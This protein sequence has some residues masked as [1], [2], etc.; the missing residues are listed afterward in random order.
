MRVFLFSDIHSDVG[1][2]RRLAAAAQAARASIVI[3]AGD[4]AEDGVHLDSVYAAFRHVGARVFAVP[5]NHDRL[6]RYGP[7]IRSAGWEDL[8]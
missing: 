8:H 7:A 5:G 1:V 6:D 4:T 3:S 2:A